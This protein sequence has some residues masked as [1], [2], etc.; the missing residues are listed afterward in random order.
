MTMNKT[1]TIYQDHR[2]DITRIIIRSGA[3]AGSDQ[4]QSRSS[5]GPQTDRQSGA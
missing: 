4:Q 3:A 2:Q 1:M 5:S